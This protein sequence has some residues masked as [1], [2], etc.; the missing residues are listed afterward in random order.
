MVPPEVHGIPHVIPPMRITV[1]APCPCGSKKLVQDCC[2]DP[3][4][5]LRVKVPSLAPPGPSTGYAH[6]KCYL[7][8]T[9][10]C[11]GK[12]SSEHY[13]SRAILELI[14]DELH[15]GGLPWEPRGTTVKYGINSLVSNILC[16]RHNSALSPLDTLAAQTFKTMR[17]VCGDL[18]H[19][20]DASGTTWHF[21]SGEALELWCLKTLCGLFFSSVAAKDGNSLKR[22]YALDVRAFDE[23]ILMRRLRPN[24]GL[25]ARL[26]TGPYHGAASWTTLS[27]DLARRFIG[28]RFRMYA[29]E[30]A[31]LLD[32][33]NVNFD[34][35]QRENIFRPWNM[36]FSDGKRMHVVVLSWPD[37]PHGYRRIDY[38]IQ[39]TLPP[40]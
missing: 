39:P 32:P 21:G 1:G 25:Y 23:A 17:A 31:V 27:V 34:V 11:S 19:Q 22:T 7:A 18:N 38:K 16:V 5:Q 8:H 24:C 13:V 6:P 14:G 20:S 4:G 12:I 30:F 15:V 35:V 10:N 28:L 9:D 26:V 40:L 33:F 3:D 2:L 36:V 37:K 29:T